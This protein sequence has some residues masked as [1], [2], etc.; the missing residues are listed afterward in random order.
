MTDVY[1]LSKEITQLFVKYEVSKVQAIF[2]L[3]AAEIAINEEMTREVIADERKGY[4]D[5]GTAGI[6]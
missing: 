6:H 5:V 4:T 2:A 3:K 1:E